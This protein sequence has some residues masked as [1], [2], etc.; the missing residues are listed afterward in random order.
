[1][2]TYGSYKR[3]DSDGIVDGELVEA[4]FATSAIT[5]AKLG[6]GAV[7]ADKLDTGSVTQA[8][9]ASGAVG[10]T[11]LSGTLDLSS[12]TVTY[13][14]ITDSDFNA[15]AALAT[16]KIS[17]PIASVTGNTSLSGGS[18][19]FSPGYFGVDK[20]YTITP[21]SSG[22]V[23][24]SI[25]FRRVQT[26]AYQWW[27]MLT[28][29]SSNT[30][31]IRYAARI[32]VPAGGSTGNVI[33]FSLANAS[34]T[35]GNSTLTAGTTYYLSWHSGDNAYSPPSGSIYADATTGG[36]IDYVQNTTP[37]ISD[38]G[39]FTTTSNNTGLRIHINF[40]VQVM[41]SGL[42][43][44]SF[45]DTT[46]ASNIS[47]GTLA[48]ARGGMGNDIGFRM[49]R[50]NQLTGS[51]QQITTWGVNSHQSAADFRTGESS[52]TYAWTS[53][54]RVTV[55]QTGTYICLVELIPYQNT[56]QIDIFVR[57]NGSNITDFRGGS[58]IGNHAACSGRLIMNLNAN[59]YIEIYSTADNGSHQGYYSS[60]SFAK[61]GGWS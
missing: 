54:N 41:G 32:S 15:G 6:T 23:I 55:Y 3:I 14:S 39:T 43:G 59:D 20:D 46:N 13:R 48:Y 29:K 47:S 21:T 53:N 7:T 45:V 52:N 5:E 44:S 57:K 40:S 11:E 36:N 50:L 1:M 61:L 51:A 56:G 25:S 4:K 24:K 33:N 18:Q 8:K 58:D 30:Y 34:A 16:S 28:T 26:S 17:G 12:K 37:T 9:I 10:T 27:F 42:A 35:V 49:Q 60:W 22:N 2:A 38:G 19:W 31:T